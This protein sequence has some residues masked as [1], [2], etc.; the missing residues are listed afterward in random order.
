MFGKPSLMTRIAIGKLI[1]FLFG[2][3][4][5]FMMPYLLPEVTM[6]LRVAVLLWYAT[7]GAIIGVFGVF[8]YHPILHLPMPWWF[9]SAIVGGWMNFVLMLFI[10][11]IV[12]PMLDAVFGADSAFATP[13]IL[14]LEGA[15]IGLVI[16][17]FATRFGGEGTE[18]A[19]K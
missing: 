10:Y 18:T 14:I 15:L 13:Y 8:S 3:I 6:M 12:Q 2:G 1:G 16:G 7:L 17:Y 4:A 9:R 19:G 5:F 11:N